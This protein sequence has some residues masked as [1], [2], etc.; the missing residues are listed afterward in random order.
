MT[1]KK[2]E[3]VVWTIL[4]QI[5]FMADINGFQDE[6]TLFIVASVRLAGGDLGKVSTPAEIKAAMEGAAEDL[7]IDVKVSLVPVGGADLA[8]PAFHGKGSERG[9]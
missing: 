9:Q 1:S 6:L 5:K 3:D 4:E 7:G 2:D 8:V